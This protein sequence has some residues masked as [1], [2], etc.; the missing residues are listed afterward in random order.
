MVPTTTTRRG[1]LDVHRGT[2]ARPK[3]SS[4]LIYC[5]LID[6]CLIFLEN[7]LKRAVLKIY[8]VC[9]YLPSALK[10]SIHLL[11]SM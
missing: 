6:L 4:H 10:Y 2:L 9:V 3:K 1:H 8:L 5:A 11:V 7:N